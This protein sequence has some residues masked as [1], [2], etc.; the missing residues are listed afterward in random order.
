MTLIYIIL[1]VFIIYSVYKSQNESFYAMDGPMKDQYI[2]CCRK[3]G[4]VS[5]KCKSMIRTYAKKLDYVGKLMT[6]DN[7]GKRKIIYLYKRYDLEKNKNVYYCRVLIRGTQ[8]YLYKKLKTK[9]DVVTGDI[10]KLYKRRFRAYVPNVTYF[11]PL[12]RNLDYGYKMAKNYFPVSFY[13]NISEYIKPF[14]FLK[15]EYLQSYR[16]SY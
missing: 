8:N 13:A 16:K 7:L 3:N 6:V 1:L 9:R 10:F 11:N 14:E 4:C 12:Y 5:S 2:R 15:P